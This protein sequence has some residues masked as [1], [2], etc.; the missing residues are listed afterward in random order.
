MEYAWYSDYLRSP[1]STSH[2]T[3]VWHDIDLISWIP[4]SFFLLISCC[5]SVTK[6]YWTLHDGIDCSMPG[7][8]VPHHLPEFAQVR[9]HW[10]SDAIQLSHPLL[11]PP[12]SF[13]ASGSFSMSQ[14]FTSGDQGIGASASV[15]P[16]SIQGWFPLRLTDLISLLSKDS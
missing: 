15:L 4:L 8:P 3:S 7:F 11:L 5:C 9:F 13:P 10:I 16:E 14:L 6:S 2:E 12:S 1:S